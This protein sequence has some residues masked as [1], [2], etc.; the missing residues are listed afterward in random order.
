MADSAVIVQ[1]LASVAMFCCCF[2]AI[3]QERVS[4][5]SVVSWASLCT[6][7]G[8]V[9]WDY[10]L[11]QEEAE[12]AQSAA[13][14]GP[15]GAEDMSSAAAATAAAKEPPQG[16]GLALP[17]DT[18]HLLGHSHNA[19]VTSIASNVSH[20]SKSADTFSDGFLTPGQPP[21]YMDPKSSLSPRAQRR[22]S[23]LKSALLIYAA[24]IGLSPF[25]TSHTKTTPRDSIWAISTWLLCMNVAFFDYGG[26]T[27]TQYAWP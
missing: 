6:L 15:D 22:I 21:P 16:L 10:W 24:V 20:A 14:D 1:H 27:G 3:V 8:W 23:T 7:L 2:V 5:V 25:Q 19:S 17:S 18:K 9:L 12:A 13:Q 11:G 26:G 4:P